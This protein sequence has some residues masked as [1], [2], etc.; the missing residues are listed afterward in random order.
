MFRSRSS[1]TLIELAVLSVHAPPEPASTTTTATAAPR[2][3][4]VADDAPALRDPAEGVP[5]GSA[6][7]GAID[8]ESVRFADGIVAIYAAPARRISVPVLPTGVK[9]LRTALGY[10]ELD[11][12]KSRAK[13]VDVA[14]GSHRVALA[15]R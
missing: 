9:V 6:R 4:L 12:K 10:V 13:E 11:V 8:L 15:I 3:R 7:S 5:V 1:S 2:L 14:V